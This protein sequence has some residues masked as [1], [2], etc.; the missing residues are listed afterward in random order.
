M[1]YRQD[2]IDRLER[3]Q[4]FEG[5]EASSSCAK[6]IHSIAFIEENEGHS[7]AR[8][9]GLMGGQ[10]ESTEEAQ[11]S[12]RD[13]DPRSLSANDKKQS[14]AIDDSSRQKVNSSHWLLGKKKNGRTRT[15]IRLYPKITIHIDLLMVTEEA[16]KQ[17]VG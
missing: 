6:E 4:E 8:K 12:S 15:T 9:A 16:E 17:S 7:S 3:R 2:R 5:G 11:A 10:G 1:N 14:P 13:T